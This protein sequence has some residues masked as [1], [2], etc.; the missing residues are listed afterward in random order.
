[1][2]HPESYCSFI[3]LS[4]LASELSAVQEQAEDF[5]MSISDP[6]TRQVFILKYCFGLTDKAIAGKLAIENIG[7]YS[8][9]SIKKIRERFVK[10][11]GIASNEA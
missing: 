10:R 1:M 7:H 9:E 3:E 8:S 5:L 4:V 2:D 11:H 6:L